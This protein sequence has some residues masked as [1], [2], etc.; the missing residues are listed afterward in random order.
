MITPSQ[1]GNIDELISIVAGRILRFLKENRIY[2]ERELSSAAREADEVWRQDPKPEAHRFEQELP[3]T[4]ENHEEQDGAR[5]PMFPFVQTCLLLGSISSGWDN[6]YIPLLS[7]RPWNSAYNWGGN[8]MWEP[9]CLILDTTDLA[10][11]FILPS[12]DTFN[13]SKKDRARWARLTLKPLSGSQ[14]LSAFGQEGKGAEVRTS[15]TAKP[16]S[17]IA[18]KVLREV[19]PLFPATQKKGD[20][21]PTCPR[22]YHSRLLATIGRHSSMGKRS[23]N[24]AFKD[25]NFEAIEAL[26]QDSTPDSEAL[27][28]K[29]LQSPSK[30]RSSAFLSSLKLYIRENPEQFTAERPIAVPLLIAALG[31]EHRNAFH[32]E[33]YRFSRL[34]GDQIVDLVEAIVAKNAQQKPLAVLDISFNPSVVPR[35]I[36]RILD[37][38]DIGELLIWDNPKLP[39]DIVDTVAR[40]RVSKVTTRD[41]F[42]APFEKWTQPWEGSFSNR[43][44]PIRTQ[45]AAAPQIHIR[46]VVFL[47][48]STRLRAGK[49][50]LSLENFDAETLAVALHPLY[51]QYYDG[52]PDHVFAEVLGL[53]LYDSWAPLAERFTSLARIEEFA[54]NHATW[55]ASQSRSILP[56]RYHRMDAIIHGEYT[57]MLLEELDHNRLRYGLVTRNAKGQLEVYNPAEVDNIAAQR[58]WQAGIGRFPAWKDE[59][60][61][62][63]ETGRGQE[64]SQRSTMLLGV[65]AVQTI[66]AAVDELVVRAEEIGRKILGANI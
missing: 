39:L 28:V 31:R 41:L 21:A 61:A 19:W 46:Q 64:T 48:L 5:T 66:C 57:I 51:K 25:R 62:V 36:S 63:P 24:G 10:Y 15:R 53:P 42:M 14:W 9:G 52:T 17:V 56:L 13:N 33:L 45:P 30:K 26:L 55:D 58:A 16:A 22:T 59:T 32:L 27:L 47:T 50:A 18:A 3:F 29:L 60:Q 34:S 2:L 44:Y 40:G 49:P 1:I 20:K 38:T 11:C 54:F 43:L 65:D 4:S 7:P 37:R 8:Y 12:E 23:K 35:H 6:S